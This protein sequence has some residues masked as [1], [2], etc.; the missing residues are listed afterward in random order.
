MSWQQQREMTPEQ[1]VRALAKLKMGQASA[2][3]FIGVSA[4]QV[5]RYIAAQRRVP[6]ST[7]LLL[8]S[9]VAHGDVP[10]VPK[11]TTRGPQW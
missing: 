4:R 1:F 7:V 2:A 10:V 11:R 9:M 8:N 3:R 6:V 5:G